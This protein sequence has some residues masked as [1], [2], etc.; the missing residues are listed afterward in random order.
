[1]AGSE[2]L[3]LLA[4]L[5]VL[6]ETQNALPVASVTPLSPFSVASLAVIPVA[7]EVTV[8]VSANA[9]GTAVPSGAARNARDVSTDKVRD[10]RYLIMLIH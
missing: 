2:G 10:C 1:L 8:V 9:V 3:V 7:G 5:N 6:V 4:T